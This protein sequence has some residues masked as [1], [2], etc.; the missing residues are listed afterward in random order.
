[1][2]K[3]I[4]GDQREYGPVGADEIRRWIGEGR[5]NARSLAKGVDGS[6]WKP[7]AEFP[8]FA[9]ALGAQMGPGVAGTQVPPALYAEAWT[10]EILAREPQVRVGECLSRSWQLMTQNF[11]LL[12]GACAFVWVVS[13]IPLVFGFFPFIGVLGS[14]AGLVYQVMSG[15]FFG[16]LYLVFLKTIRGEKTNPGEAFS[17]F[18][19]DFGQLL[20]AGFLS[21]LL[22]NIGFCLCILPGIYLAVAWVFC[23]PL[24]ADKRLEFWSAMELSRKVVTKVW[25]EVLALIVVAFLPIILAWLLAGAK[26]GRSLI[27]FFHQVIS[28][29]GQPDFGRMMQNMISY[30]TSMFTLSFFS[31][32][33]LL[34]N[35]PFAVGALMYAYE[36]LF[37]P[38]TPA[39]A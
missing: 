18:Q 17:G 30:N 37:G 31:R 34:F 23:V 1:M 11:G 15:V 14:L 20:L 22:E 36:N 19:I 9:E 6:E 27:P 16:G 38:R 8:E 29:G 5:L 25:I 2:F 28:A 4:G 21:G 35:L 26:I 10:A 7:L 13:V 33:V 39:N 32:L 3:I 24:V 12:L